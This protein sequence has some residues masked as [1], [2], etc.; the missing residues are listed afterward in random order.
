MPQRYCRAAMSPAATVAAFIWL[1]CCTVHTST[2]SAAPSASAAAGL[3]LQLVSNL[4]LSYADHGSGASM[5]LSAWAPSC[6]PETT[7]PRCS[8]TWF[9]VGHAPGSKFTSPGTSIVALAGA[10]PTALAPPVALYTNWN[11]SHGTAGGVCACVGMPCGGKCV[12]VY[13]SCCNTLC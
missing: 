8:Q 1:P 10:D 4:Q 6:G 9:S 12:P 3:Q 5:D 7:T 13:A 2:A 11:T